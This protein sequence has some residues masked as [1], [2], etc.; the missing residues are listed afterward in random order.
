MNRRALLKALGSSVLLSGGFMPPLVFAQTVPNVNSP[1]F[2]TF[3]TLPEPVEIQRV[4]AASPSA[5]VMLNSLT[6]KQLLGWPMPLPE[7]A[8]R[9]LS[10]SSRQ[11]PIIGGLTGPDSKINAEQLITLRPDIIVDVC[12][13]TAPHLEFAKQFSKQTGIPYVVVEAK[14]ETSPEQ[15]R[16]LGAL[17]GHQRHGQQLAQAA[18]AVFDDIAQKRTM[19]NEQLPSIYVACSADGLETVRAHSTFNDIIRLVGAKNVVQSQTGDSETRVSLEQLMHWNPDIIL[20]Q[21]RDFLEQVYNHPLWQQL[22]AVQNKKVLFVPEAPFSWMSE[23]ASINQL[24]GLQWLASN[25]YAEKAEQL[26]EKV[27]HL[28][29]LFFAMDPGQERIAALLAKPESFS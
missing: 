27:R 21:S 8:L 5:G 18:Q 12:D 1:L 22:K 9:W 16:H 7:K 20:T 15:L 25:L 26:V 17:L 14:L 6:P 4:F 29:I 19:F 13:A 10:E 3:G 28:F 2:H 11:L 24:F 23:P